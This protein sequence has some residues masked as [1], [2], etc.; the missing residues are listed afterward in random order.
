MLHMKTTIKYE[1]GFLTARNRNPE[2]FEFIKSEVYDPELDDFDFEKV[3]SKIKVANYKRFCDSLLKLKASKISAYWRFYKF[4]KELVIFKLSFKKN[5]VS[6]NLDFDSAELKLVYVFENNKIK[7]ILDELFG[8]D[9]EDA[10]TVYSSERTYNEILINPLVLKLLIGCKL[11]DSEN[12]DIYRNFHKIMPNGKDRLLSEPNKEIKGTLVE[13]NKFFQK[14]YG[15]K[16][17]GIQTAY[18]TGLSVLD[19]A[20]P[21]KDN[22]YMFK[23]DIKNFFPSCKRPLVEKYVKYAFLGSIN[24]EYLL[25]YFLDK[26]LVDDALCLGNPISSTL[27][28]QIVSGPAKYIYNICNK[29]NIAFTQYCDDVTFSSNQPLSKDWVVKIFNTA[30]EQFGL[31]EYF[32]LNEK[33]LY[34]LCGQ[35]RNT[36]GIAFDHTNNNKPTC[37]RAI[38][39]YVRVNVN[40][41]HWGKNPNINMSK[42]LGN[43]AYMIMCG[44]GP[45]VLRYLNKFGEK[46]KRVFM[47]EETEQKI[48]DEYSIELT[49]EE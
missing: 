4:E 6:G 48:L 23:G 27:A 1:N 11:I 12:Q 28:N 25:E 8:E 15:M 38:W 31:T 36:T 35:Y 5:S 44:Q 46:T 34:G 26:M 13:L 10:I 49:Q 24:K 43:I 29:N 16:N 19:N 20:Y 3:S 21:H 32:K 2:K 14:A 17:Y 9:F 40:N 33:K 45:R 41:Y 47:S 30:Y 7:G 18:K 39:Y 22:Y 42:V 37:K